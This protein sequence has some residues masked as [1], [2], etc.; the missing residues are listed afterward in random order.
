MSSKPEDSDLSNFAIQLNMSPLDLEAVHM[1]E[2][3]NSLLRAGFLERQALLLVAMIATETD[4]A[5]AQYMVIADDEDDDDDDD[6]DQ[7]DDNLEKT[8]D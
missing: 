3:Y 4:D 2:L 6:D 1:Y 5:Q 7:D 8:K